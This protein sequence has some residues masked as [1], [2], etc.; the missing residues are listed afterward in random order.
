MLK[1]QAKIVIEGKELTTVKSVSIVADLEAREDTATVVLALANAADFKERQKIEIALGYTRYGLHPEFSGYIVEVG[2]NQNDVELKCS[3]GFFLL[4]QESVNKNYKKT[5]LENICKDLVVDVEADGEAKKTKV[6]KYYAPRLS[7]AEV[8]KR[9]AKKYGFMAFF[10]AGVLKVVSQKTLEQRRQKEQAIFLEGQNIIENNLTYSNQ[11][12]GK[13]TVV[14]EGE[15]GIPRRS[16][17]GNGEPEKIVYADGLMQADRKKRAKEIFEQAN[18]NFFE[19]DF[20]T[21]GYPYVSKGDYVSVILADEKK[22]P[23]FVLVSKIETEFGMGGF[24]RRV[25]VTVQHKSVLP[26]TK[27]RFM[28]F[29]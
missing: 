26:Q 6:Q 5:T 16:S 23:A 12:V 8:I 29:W 11:K 14:S 3:D 13:V 21:F 18:G 1:L 7:K 28:R 9:L 17:Y 2:K 4:R 19:G 24:R 15:D 22:P 20:L 25:F 10:E 27:E